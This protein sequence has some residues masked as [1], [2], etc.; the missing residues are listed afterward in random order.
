LAS[1]EV[2]ARDV[3]GLIEA[4]KGVSKKEDTETDSKNK[5]KS[6]I[7]WGRRDQYDLATNVFADPVVRRADERAL[8]ASRR[9]ALLDRAPTTGGAAGA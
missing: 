4:F 3:Y 2:V 7:Q 9:Q 8:R 5:T 1:L 6:K